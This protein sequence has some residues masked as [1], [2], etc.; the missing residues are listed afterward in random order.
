MTSRSFSYT[1]LQAPLSNNG[2]ACIGRDLRRDEAIAGA[3]EWI[4]YIPAPRFITLITSITS[5]DFEAL[6]SIV[7]MP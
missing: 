7:R 2:S 4:R 3:E 5:D 6:S 1:F